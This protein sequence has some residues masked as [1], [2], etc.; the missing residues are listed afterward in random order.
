MESTAPLIP[1]RERP[2]DR[3]HDLAPPPHADGSHG[4][5][6]L[7]AVDEPEELARFTRWES[8]I[9]G[10]RLGV[11]ALQ[12]SGMHCAAC[13][14]IIESALCALPGVRAAHVNASAQRA[15]VRWDPR[16]V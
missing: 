16:Q 8:G 15:S 7:A 9:E 1:P 10:E 4:R 12:L 6:R 2:A 11:S 13:A 3:I 14:G 5:D